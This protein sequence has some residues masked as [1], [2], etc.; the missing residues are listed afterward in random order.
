MR[1]TIAI[2]SAGLL[3]VLTSPVEADAQAQSE[4]AQAYAAQC[5]LC[6]GTTGKGDGPAAVAFNPKPGD[7]SDPEFWKDKED[8]AVAAIIEDGKG[9]MPGFGSSLDAAQITA[10]VAYLKGLA[11]GGGHVVGRLAP[12]AA[13]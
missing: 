2:L 1:K 13:R 8:A 7:F 10:M 5:A 3:V 6:H 12:P 4:S 11:E 9:A